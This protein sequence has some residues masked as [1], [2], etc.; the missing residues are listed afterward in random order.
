MR[1]IFE[2]LYAIHP[3]LPIAY[4]AIFVN[5]AVAPVLYCAVKGAPLDISRVLGLAKSGSV[6]AKYVL[7]SWLFLVLASVVLV[8]AILLA[9]AL[10]R[11]A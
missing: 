6:G 11:A 1:Q 8:A 9:W 10:G 2:I 4:F 5:G 7:A 3:L